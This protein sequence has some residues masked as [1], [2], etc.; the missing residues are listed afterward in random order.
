MANTSDTLAVLASFVGKVKD[1][2]DDRI[3]REG[4]LIRADDPAVKKW[5]EKFGPPNL[6]HEPRVEQ[7]TAAPG[8][9]R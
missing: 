2:E 5:P 1:G 9:K 8:E 3:F 4:E 6:P 7:A